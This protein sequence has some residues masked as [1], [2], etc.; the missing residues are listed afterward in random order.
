AV[1]FGNAGIG[2]IKQGPGSMELYDRANTYSGLTSVEAGELSAYGANVT[3][4]S[5]AAGT[6]VSSGAQ[7]QISWANIGAE[8]LQLNGDAPGGGEIFTAH[9]DA[10]WAGAVTL[11]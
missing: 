9:G 5:T 2:F 8:S 7:L 3:L 1:I 4:G 11:N 10:S 6:V